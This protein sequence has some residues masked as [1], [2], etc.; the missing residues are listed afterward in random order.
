MAT[1][2]TSC[3]KFETGLDAYHDGELSAVEKDAVEKHLG[4]CPACNAKL[5]DIDRLVSSLK[6]L[7]RVGLSRDFSA[8]LDNILSQ[9]AQKQIILLQP[10]VWAPLS[11]AAAIILLVLTFKLVPQPGHNTVAV[12]TPNK[13]VSPE[14]QNEPAPASASQGQIASTPVFPDNKGQA[15]QTKDNSA[16]TVKPQI[17]RQDDNAIKPMA[18]EKSASPE[19]ASRMQVEEIPA[20]NNDNKVSENFEIAE[21]SNQNGSFMEAVGITTDE[22]G[23]YDL[24][25]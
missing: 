15:S 24:K 13:I 18:A 11:I 5:A 7:P 4:Q 21:V 20:I 10:K 8:N 23:L 22:D 12:S 9:P 3:T 25:M 19:I 2:E 16:P 1:S 17:A 6:H 14:K